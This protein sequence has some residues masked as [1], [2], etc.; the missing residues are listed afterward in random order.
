MDLD[1]VCELFAE[2]PFRMTS[3]HR[4]IIS[5]LISIARAA[6]DWSENESENSEYLRD[7]LEDLSDY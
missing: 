6:Y 2:R 1:D 3:E 5:R 7:K 4:A